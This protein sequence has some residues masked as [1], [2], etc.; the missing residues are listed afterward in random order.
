MSDITIP[1]ADA[2][3]GTWNGM[4]STEGYGTAI[5]DV[6][7]EPA[8]DPAPGLVPCPRCTNSVVELEDHLNSCTGPGNEPE[9]KLQA[10]PLAEARALIEEDRRQRQADCLAEIRIVLDKYGMDLQ[11]EP[12]RIALVPVD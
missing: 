8:T 4:T 1:M 9:P 3:P 10:N 6:H 7:P 2:E 12:A 11:V 5:P